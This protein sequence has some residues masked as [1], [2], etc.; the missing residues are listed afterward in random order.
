MREVLVR[1]CNYSGGPSIVPVEKCR[2]PATICLWV[3]LTQMV[4][5]GGV[6]PVAATEPVLLAFA[7]RHCRRTTVYCT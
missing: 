2:L 3:R 5:V 1:I 4:V 6:V 7:H